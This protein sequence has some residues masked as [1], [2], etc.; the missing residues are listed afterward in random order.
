MSSKKKAQP[1]LDTIFALPLS[2]QFYF[3]TQTKGLENWSS[4]NTMS[5][6]D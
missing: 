2:S 3:Q 6:S 5:T 4:R 1:E